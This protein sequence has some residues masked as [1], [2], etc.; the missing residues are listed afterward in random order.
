MQYTIAEENGEDEHN[1]VD[2]ARMIKP[3]G[4]TSFYCPVALKQ[5]LVLWPGSDD[6]GVKY[7]DKLY[8]CSSDEAKEAFMSR[9]DDFVAH[10]EPL[11][12]H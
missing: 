4:D 3:W 2:Y 5:Q 8:Y 12:V 9:V 7:R 1:E 11:Q 10:N 6:Y